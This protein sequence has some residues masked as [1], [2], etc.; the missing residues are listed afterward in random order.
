MK[1]YGLFWCS[2]CRLY[3]H[4]VKRFGLFFCTNHFPW[5]IILR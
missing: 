4:R 5:N 3:T 2:R 1:Y